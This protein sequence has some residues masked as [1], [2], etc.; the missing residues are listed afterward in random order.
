MFGARSAKSFL[1]KNSCSGERYG[2]H[3]N[4]GGR[5]DLV[6]GEKRVNQGPNRV[7]TFEAALR[8]HWGIVAF[9]IRFDPTGMHEQD[10][11]AVMLCRS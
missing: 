2:V 8:I 4:D 11:A 7:K 5:F 10:G 3:Q 9:D 6:V 1:I